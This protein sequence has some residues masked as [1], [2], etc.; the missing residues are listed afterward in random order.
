MSRE[1]R[2]A[3]RPRFRD[4]WADFAA[5]AGRA[6]AGRGVPRHHGLQHAGRAAGALRRRNPRPVGVGDHASDR[7]W[8]AGA[9]AG[10]RLAG[11]GWPGLEPL[12]DGGR[13]SWRVAAFSPVIFA[14]P[15]NS[16]ALFFAG[17]TL[18]GFGGG[19]F[20]VSTLT[21]AMTM[22]ATGQRRRGWRWAPGARRRPPRRGCPSPWAA[23]CATGRRLATTGALGE[24][25]PPPP[26]A[27]PS[28]ITSRSACSSSRWR[29]LGPLV[30]RGAHQPTKGPARSAWPISRPDPGPIRGG[31]DMTNHSL[32][33][34]D[35]ASLSIW[36]FWLFFAG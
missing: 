23:A 6:P 20:A 4:A 26:P 13:G 3:P 32:A 31:H 15:M 14:A 16:P 35:L 24:G 28:S 1:E 19:L 29:A 25:W 12:P 34:F 30:R 27:T 18:I 9:L 17:A 5:A 10:F 21:A 33:N 22:P 8:A 7:A 11:G 2:E 36:L